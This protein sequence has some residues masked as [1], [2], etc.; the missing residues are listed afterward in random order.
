ME[1]RWGQPSS[2]SGVSNTSLHRPSPESHRSEGVV[3]TVHVHVMYT[4]YIWA[5][6]VLQSYHGG[7]KKAPHCS[8]P[9]I[10]SLLTRLLL[11]SV[12]VLAVDVLEAVAS[13]VPMVIGGGVSCLLLRLVGLLRRLLAVPEYPG[14][15]RACWLEGEWVCLNVVV[16]SDLRVLRAAAAETLKKVQ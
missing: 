5:C 16:S 8:M 4:V 12:D 6:T 9:S 13:E 15:R 3:I 1:T 10:L 2:R 14:L 7:A 11:P